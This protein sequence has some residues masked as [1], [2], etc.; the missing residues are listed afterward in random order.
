M[1]KVLLFV[2]MIVSATFV[3]GQE[4][5]KLETIQKNEMKK[6]TRI[7][8]KVNKNLVFNKNQTVKLEGVFTEKAKEIIALRQQE[9]GKGEYVSAHIKIDKKYLP[10]VEA[11][12]TTEQ[13]IAY[14]KNKKNHR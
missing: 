14:R 9:L 1:K 13:K 6:L 7:I 10:K 8:T 5:E 2:L 4:M 3:S 12:L 11:L